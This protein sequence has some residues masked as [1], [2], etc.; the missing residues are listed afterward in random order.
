M[1][2]ARVDRQ[3]PAHARPAAAPWQWDVVRVAGGLGVL[4]ATAVTP[5]TSRVL[6]QRAV[7]LVC[8]AYLLLILAAALGRLDDGFPVPLGVV[9]VVDALHLLWGVHAVTG[10]GFVVAVAAVLLT[11]AAV[12]RFS[13]SPAHLDTGGTR[14]PRPSD[15]WVVGEQSR[16]PE[17]PSATGPAEPMR[18]S[19]HR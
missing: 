13:E 2:T 5:V 11:L 15:P 14:L 1:T 6:D 17:R 9:L 7:A 16:P 8:G 19:S 4:G 12:L 10:S 3:A 18:S